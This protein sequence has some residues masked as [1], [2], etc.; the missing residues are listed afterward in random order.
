MGY[1]DETNEEHFNRMA[2]TLILITLLLISIA[3]AI[4][5]VNAYP[6]DYGVRDFEPEYIKN[7]SIAKIHV[8]HDIDELKSI[9]GSNSMGCAYPRGE[10]CELYVRHIESVTRPVLIEWGHELSH[11]TYGGWHD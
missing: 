4:Y 11:C 6:S 9:C 10:Y 8:I 3:T 5:V 2:G 1:N 7:Y